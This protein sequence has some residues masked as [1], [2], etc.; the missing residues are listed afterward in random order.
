MLADRSIRT[1]G[2]SLSSLN[3]RALAFLLDGFVSMQLRHALLE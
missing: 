3:N 2:G 1:L